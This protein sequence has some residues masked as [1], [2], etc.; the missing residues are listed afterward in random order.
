MDLKL[1]NNL[2]ELEKFFENRMCEYEEKL[3]KASAGTG[4][5]AVTDIATLSREFFEFK[6]LV[7]P[8]PTTL[9]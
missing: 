6:S 9:K 4:A 7:M 3:K 8:S 5:A 2:E 1:A